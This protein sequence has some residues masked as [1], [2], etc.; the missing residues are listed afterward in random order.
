M[1]T[2][3]SYILCYNSVMYQYST[4]Y[5]KCMFTTVYIYKLLNSAVQGEHDFVKWENL[6]TMHTVFTVISALPIISAPLQ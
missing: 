1:S 5:T 3:I 4:W 2:E 6:M